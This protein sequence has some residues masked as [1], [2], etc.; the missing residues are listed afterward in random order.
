ML[1][2]TM[3]FS[4]LMI[5]LVSLHKWLNPYRIPVLI[6]TPASKISQT[7]SAPAV[8]REKEKGK[9]KCSICPTKLASVSVTLFFKTI[10][11]IHSLQCF[12]HRLLLTKY[13]CRRIKGRAGPWCHST[14]RNSPASLWS[15]THLNILRIAVA[16]FIL[17]SVLFNVTLQG[18]YKERSFVARV[19][20]VSNTRQCQRDSKIS[21]VTWK[22][23]ETRFH[24]NSLGCSGGGKHESS[25][26]SRHPHFLQILR[27]LSIDRG[28]GRDSER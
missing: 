23:S 18:S 8:A 14:A 9:C 12:V 4:F 3:I 16:S 17:T 26:S 24:T 21:L 22:L 13:L 11:Y 1:F 28:R 20:L 19:W 15:Q 27:C 2:H 25:L 10:V 7:K 6:S 5:P